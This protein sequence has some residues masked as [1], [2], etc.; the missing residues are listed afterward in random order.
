VTRLRIRRDASGERV[1]TV[2]A[3]TLSD[4]LELV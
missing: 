1:W 4:E 2:K 3:V